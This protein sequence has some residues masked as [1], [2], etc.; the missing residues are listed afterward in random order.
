MNPPAAVSFVVVNAVVV[1]CTLFQRLGF[2][3]WRFVDAIDDFLRWPV[4][5]QDGPERTV[6]RG[7]PVALF[8]LSRG[9]MGD[10]D[11]QRSVIAH[12]DSLRTAPNGV[13]LDRVLDQPAARER[14]HRDGPEEL[15]RLLHLLRA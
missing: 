11:G 7:E 5:A 1:W 9:F 13:T 2:V 8:V 3:G 12:T 14:V 15:H 4:A 6:W 10:V